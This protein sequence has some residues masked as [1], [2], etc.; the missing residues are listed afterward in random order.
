VLACISEERDHDV[1]QEDGVQRIVV[2]VDGSES[3][4]EALT[5]A[6]RYAREV[7]G[8]LT[9][10]IAWHYPP[11]PTGP[12]MVPPTD[13]E[14]EESARSVL[15]RAIAQADEGDLV[16]VEQVVAQGSAAAVLIDRSRDAD[17]LVVGTRGHGGFAG[18]LL[19]SVSAPCV[20]H[21]HCPVV[22]VR[23]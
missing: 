2:G 21:A 17:L 12:G 10:V 4:Q 7:G 9:A 3:G 5:W 14:P 1:V 23:S 6:R 13:Y 11:M 8:R 20:H 18:M 16:G 19:G 15:A 22:V